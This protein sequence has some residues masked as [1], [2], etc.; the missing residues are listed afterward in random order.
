MTVVAK[1]RGRGRLGFGIQSQLSSLMFCLPCWQDG[2]GRYKGKHQVLTST[3][4]VTVNVIDAQDMPPSFVGT[5]YF[6]YIYEVSLPVSSPQFSTIQF[7]ES[8]FE[9]L[10]IYLSFRVRKYSQCML[11]METRATLTPSIIPF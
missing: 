7:E 8:Y 11:K 10:L 4:T 6:G 9:A 2:G 3:A 1:V 5:P